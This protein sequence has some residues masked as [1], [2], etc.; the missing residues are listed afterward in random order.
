M[1]NK[2]CRLLSNGIKVISWNGELVGAPCCYLPVK[3]LTDPGFEQTMQKYHTADKCNGCSYVAHNTAVDTTHPPNRA[4][5]LVDDCDHNYPVYIELSIDNRCNAACLSCSDS[6]SSTWIEQNKKFNIKTVDDYPDPQDDANVV[7]RL[8]QH[9]NL[10]YAKEFNI[11]GGDPIISHTTPLVL[12]R[13]IDMGIA[14]DI[15]ISFVTNAS[16][17]LSEELTEIL[18]QFKAVHFS[19]SLDGIQDRFEYL[20]YPLKWKKVLRTI[21]TINNLST[22]RF[23]INSTINPLN[24]FYI[25]ELQEWASNNF[26]DKNIKIN[27][28]LCMGTMSLAALP[29][30][31]KEF[32]KP[33]HVDRPALHLA[34]ITR[35]REQ[36]IHDFLNYLKIW[37]GNRKNSWKSMFPRALEFY[38]EYL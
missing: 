3:P 27:M 18:A 31:A 16:T 6:F 8:F 10:E 15:S 14:H 30:S 7:E 37:D 35:S 29:N 1:S 26:R 13:L 21:D 24:I 32:L 11:Q 5:Q 2:F 9:I 19:L 36:E 25:D 38:K 28:P 4:L 22:A 12:K 23:S 17:P 20:R 33:L 34:L